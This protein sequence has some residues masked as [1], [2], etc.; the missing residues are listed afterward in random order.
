M[1][2]NNSNTIDAISLHTVLQRMEL[3]LVIDWEDE[4]DEAILLLQ[5]KLSFYLYYIEGGQLENHYPQAIGK[6]VCIQILTRNKLSEEVKSLLL[7][8]EK[9]LSDLQID[10]EVKQFDRKNLT[11]IASLL[12][13]K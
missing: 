2:L 12:N 1:Y 11:F 9:I 10:L 3:V 8:V 7:T 13:G 5:D 4:S 6:P